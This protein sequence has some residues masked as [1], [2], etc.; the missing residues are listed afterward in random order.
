MFGHGTSIRHFCSDFRFCL[1]MSFM[2]PLSFS[3][4]LTGLLLLLL[5][6]RAVYHIL[7]AEIEVI[8]ADGEAET[9]LVV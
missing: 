5:D 6:Q 7:V 2:F 9:E 4:H 8:L 1:L 3:P